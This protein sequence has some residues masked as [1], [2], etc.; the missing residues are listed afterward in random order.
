[1]NL[2]KLLYPSPNNAYIHY[3]SVIM[4]INKDNNV[5]IPVP[6]SRIAKTRLVS[7]IVCSIFGAPVLRCDQNTIQ[8]KVT[9]LYNTYKFVSL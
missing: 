8:W 4:S 3:I 7:D 2:F 9:P 5:M 1:M 6:Q